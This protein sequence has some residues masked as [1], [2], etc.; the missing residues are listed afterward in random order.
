MFVFGVPALFLPVMI[1]VLA[2][3][4]VLR[5]VLPYGLLLVAAYL[6]GLIVL[7]MVRV[8]AL[9]D[10]L[11][12]LVAVAVVYLA[13]L[14]TPST[15]L[16]ASYPIHVLRCGGL[17]VV[18][19]DFASPMTY[20]IPRDDDYGITPLESHLFCTENEARVAGY[21]RNTSTDS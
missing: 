8:R 19:T 20:S 2:P 18:T 12:A 1:V 21:D 9:P 11:R 3:G 17:P 7:L 5:F 15:A 10:W 14:V 13:A 6:A 4:G 16:M